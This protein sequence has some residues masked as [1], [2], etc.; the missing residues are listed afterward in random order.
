MS[1]FYVLN[2]GCRATQADGAALECDLLGRGLSRAPSAREAEVVVLNTCTVTAEADRDVRAA[3]RRVH[4]ENPGCRIL[5]TGCYAQRAPRELDGLPGVAWVVG[6]SHKHR[7]G[8]ILHDCH[9]ERA[10]FASEGPL[11]PA[12]SLASVHI[13]DIF[14]HTELMAAPVFDGLGYDRTRPNLKVQDG[15]DNRCSFC[16]IPLVRGQSRSLRREDVLREMDALVAAGFREVVISGINL[17]R[18]GRDLEPPARF[19][20]LVR[21]ILAHTG[22]ERLRLSSIEPMDWTDELID[23]V[24]GSRRIARHAH[25]PLQTGSDRVLRRM[26]RKYRPWHYEERIRKIRAAMPVAAIGA[27]VMAGFP[28]ETEAEFEENRQFIASLP[29]TYLHVFTYS[30]RPGTPAADMQNQLPVEIK[31]ERNRILR[32][33]AAEKKQEFMRSLVGQTVSTITLSVVEDGRTE[34]LTDNYQKLWLEGPRPANQIVKA[35]V[36]AI[37]NDSLIGLAMDAG[38]NHPI[39]R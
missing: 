6:N 4:R 32:E 10:A 20:D 37:S 18:W 14:A 3:I 15:C 16:I 22:V 12:E 8:E 23:L 21:A 27:D 19:E 2:F 5:V 13:G 25:V 11:F 7:V 35:R 39:P 24:A 17:G 30:A 29:F 28:G 9:P 1:S 33:L 36:R 34:T 38:F 31:R 26:H